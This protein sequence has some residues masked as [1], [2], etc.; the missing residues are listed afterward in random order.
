MLKLARPCPSSVAVPR[1]VAPSESVTDPVG[2]AV[3]DCAVTVVVKVIVWPNV[4]G[5]TEVTRAVALD[6][7]L[8]VSEN[9]PDEAA[10]LESPE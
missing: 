2:I 10:K 1:L 5:L 3:P 8:I 7:L 4:L 6:A 9:V